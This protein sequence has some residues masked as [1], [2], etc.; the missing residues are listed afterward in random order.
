MGRSE[1]AGFLTSPAGSLL[2]PPLPLPSSHPFAEENDNACVKIACWL[3]PL[4]VSFLP[5]SEATAFHSGSQRCLF[6]GLLAPPSLLP[7]FPLHHSENFLALLYTVG[8]PWAAQ[9]ALAAGEAEP[10]RHLLSGDGA[11]SLLVYP[12]CIIYP[13]RNRLGDRYKDGLHF[14]TPKRMSPK[15]LTCIHTHDSEPPLHLGRRRGRA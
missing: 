13:D 10:T 8:I 11:E 15:R 4:P 2:V 7:C 6:Q 14:R 12:L 1:D 9:W 5:C 3:E